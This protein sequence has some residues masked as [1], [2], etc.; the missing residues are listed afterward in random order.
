MNMN[1]NKNKL[2]TI[3]QAANASHT[4]I[5]KDGSL[6]VNIAKYLASDAGRQFIRKYRNGVEVVPDRRVVKLDEEV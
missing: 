4:K 6:T 2:L 3:K 1:M 5:S